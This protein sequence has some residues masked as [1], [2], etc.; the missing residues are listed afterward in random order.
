MILKIIL[1]VF[2]L[3]ALLWDLKT[4]KI[5]NLLNL[6]GG[7]LG[8]LLNGCRFGLDGIRE[9]VTGMGIAIG[10]L[11]IPYLLRGI[12]AGDVKLLMAM[13]C[14]MGHRIWRLLCYTGIAGGCIAIILWVRKGKKA[15]MHFTIPIVLGTLAWMLG[16]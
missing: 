8:L 12:G 10:I 13:G 1:L 14:L 11:F 7:S 2:V 16:G 6:T 9:G 5:P 15:R 4:D 3:L